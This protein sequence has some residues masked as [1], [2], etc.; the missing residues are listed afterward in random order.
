MVHISE[1]YQEW[2]EKK[3]KASVKLKATFNT[4]YINKGF[5]V[6]SIYLYIYLC[7]YIYICVCVWCVHFLPLCILG[8][9]DI[10]HIT[11]GFHKQTLQWRLDAAAET[12]HGSYGFCWQILG[13]SC[14][15]SSNSGSQRFAS[16]SLFF[17]AIGAMPGQ[18]PDTWLK[19]RERRQ[20]KKWLRL[21]IDDLP[22]WIRCFLDATFKGKVP[23]T[24]GH[25]SKK[26]KMPSLLSGWWFQLP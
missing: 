5:D 18:V 6:Q 23:D 16:A 2:R 1:Q 19:E 7:I 14:R 20:K 24:P 26:P 10:L 9:L 21:N 12:T 25:S 4:C 8:F 15:L 22:K 3:Q 13:V 17:P 11:E